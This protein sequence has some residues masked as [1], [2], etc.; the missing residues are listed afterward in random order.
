MK[1][2]LGRERG[3]DTIVVIILMFTLPAYNVTP[4][5]VFLFEGAELSLSGACPGFLLS[6]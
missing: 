6:P 1:V 3:P 4:V 2:D 5:S